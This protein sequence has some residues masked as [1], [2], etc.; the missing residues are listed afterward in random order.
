MKLG[1]DG[2]PSHESLFLLIS[3]VP[4]IGVIGTSQII[5]PSFF[6]SQKSSAK[7]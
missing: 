1:S 4:A 2:K 6:G 5:Q 7:D 3:H